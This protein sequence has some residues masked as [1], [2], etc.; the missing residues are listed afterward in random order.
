MPQRILY[1]VYHWG[2]GHATRSLLLIRALVERGAAVTILMQE[3]PGLALLRAELGERCDYF[4]FKDTPAPLGRNPA[5]FYL[6]MSLS[7]PS[8]LAGFRNEH[9]LTERLV[10][11][12]GLDCVVSDSRFGV[13]SSVVPSYFLCHSLRQIVPGRWR[14]LE[15]LVEWGQRGL[16]EG[17]T[18]VLIPDVEEHG[19]L[20]GYLG[21]D[22]T[23]DW[24]EG[25]IVYIGPLSAVRRDGFPEDI[26]IF[27]SV[28]GLGLPQRD[29]GQLVLD[30]L[31]RLA[32]R[33]VVT[34]GRPEAAGEV[35]TIAGATVHGYLE[36]ERQAE[37]LNRARLVVARSG[38]TL[39]MELA[40]LGKHAL[41]VPTPGQ[42]EQEYLAD[43]HRERGHVWSTAQKTVDLVRD[44][45]RAQAAAGLPRVSPAQSVQRFLAVLD[46]GAPLARGARRHEV[47][48]QRHDGKVEPPDRRRPHDAKPEHQREAVAVADARGARG[49]HAQHVDGADLAEDA[50]AEK[51]DRQCE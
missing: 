46:R 24:G 42:S 26:D 30:T 1:A 28:S 48:Q 36:R 35:R 39:L 29:F 16:L 32:G 14:W 17:F 20:S 21:H 22:P 40:E 15:R 31:P 45:P 41:F 19:G 4:P 27:C 44:I 23:F 38:Y 43:Y 7:V 37:M 9:R 3:G 50:A 12:R 2:L 10:R 33:I 49:D 25:R 6:R 18:K 5:L 51:H 47:P 8:I 34:L 11:E 13:W